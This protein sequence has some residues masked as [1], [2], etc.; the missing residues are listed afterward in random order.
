MMKKLILV[1]AAIA[2]LAYFLPTS[3]KLEDMECG[4]LLRQVE[5]HNVEAEPL[6]KQK[7]TF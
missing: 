1:A 2:A 7:C 5:A 4:D 6:Y 3:S